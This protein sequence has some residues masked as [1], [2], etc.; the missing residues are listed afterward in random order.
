MKHAD[1]H[2]ISVPKYMKKEISDAVVKETY[3]RKGPLALL[4][5]LPVTGIVGTGV[6]FIVESLAREIPRPWVSGSC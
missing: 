4:F 6:Y 2:M 3:S 5:V 1:G